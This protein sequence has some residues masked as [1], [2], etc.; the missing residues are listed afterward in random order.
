MEVL[1]SQQIQPEQNLPL[2]GTHLL[3]GEMRGAPAAS[4]LAF[5]LSAPI[6]TLKERRWN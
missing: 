5:V 4:R 3:V 6:S 2:E 1:P